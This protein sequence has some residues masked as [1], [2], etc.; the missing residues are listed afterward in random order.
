MAWQIPSEL[1]DATVLDTEGKKHR[2]GDSWKSHP[3]VLVF[4]RHFG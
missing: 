4:I 2:L 1:A 3:V